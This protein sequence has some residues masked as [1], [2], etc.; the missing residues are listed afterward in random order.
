MSTNDCSPLVPDFL[1][2]HMRRVRALAFSP[3]GRWL[4][5]GSN[6]RKVRLWDLATSKRRC[7]WR[8]KSWAVAGLAFSPDNIHIAA[9]CQ[10]CNGSS[11]S[12]C[13]AFLCRTIGGEIEELAC[14]DGER[15]SSYR[16]QFSPD[17][18]MLAVLHADVTLYD[19]MNG[20]LSHIRPK[21]RITSMVFT[22]DGSQLVLGMQDGDLQVW[23]VRTK[24]K[25]RTLCCH[26]SFVTSL[27]ISQ[28]G[29]LL[30]S[31]SSA[32]LEQIELEHTD[33]TIRILDF[34]SGTQ[35]RRFTGTWDAT[36]DL[37][38]IPGNQ[39]IS[40]HDPGDQ[41]AVYFWSA[42]KKEGAVW[43]PASPASAFAVDQKG[44]QLA[45]GRPGGEI[46]FLDLENVR[47]GAKRAGTGYSPVREVKRRK[48]KPLFG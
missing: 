19:M 25:K 18:N 2:A 14:P 23:H 21:G 36:M 5:S 27:A 24:K 20:Q 38:F 16:P 43:N 35:L 33:S 22:P 44:T 9:I 28:D 40:F 29:Q 42:E 32:H 6:D 31:A 10:K 1:R 4:A 37:A 12:C 39:L 48:F 45:F 8:P 46:N 13:T 41:S 47:R 15:L 30:A 34:K 7:E 3:N 26:D 17:G 11:R